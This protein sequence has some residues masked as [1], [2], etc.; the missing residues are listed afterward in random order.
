M[1]Y[2]FGPVNSRRLGRSLGVDLVPIKT[3]SLNCIYCECGETTNCTDAIA[4]YVP[5]AEVVDE[6]RECLQACPLLDVITFSGFGEPTLHSGLGE[7]VAFLRREF[8]EYRVALLT[9]ATRFDDPDVR[10]AVLAIDVIIP[11][12]DAAGEDAFRKIARP[13]PGITAKRIIRGL[14]ELRREYRGEMILELFIVSGIND[15]EDELKK[16]KEAIAM[17]GPD[18]VH[19]NTLDRPGAVEW[20]QPA[21]MDRLRFVADFLAP[22]PVEIVG[23]P[24]H[25]GP[26]RPAGGDVA[27]TIVA[28][29]ARRPS[30]LEDLS[31]ALGLPAADVNRTVTR[32]MNDGVLEKRQSGRGNFYCLRERT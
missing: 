30:T 27:N 3:C 32:L 26:V 28:T 18:R 5:T 31:S 29:V 23:K 4:E 25:A 24:A 17:I 20:I 2:L 7:I 14:V 11:S 16:L 15:T 9:N 13:A 1:K 22:Y 8:P 19:L 12:L 10:R 6:L 21:P